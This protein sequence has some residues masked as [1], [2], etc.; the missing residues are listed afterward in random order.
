M[1]NE[2]VLNILQELI[3]D[4]NDLADEKNRMIL[5]AGGVYKTIYYSALA[6]GI[7]EA[8]YKVVE[9]KDELRKLSVNS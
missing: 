8:C 1:T 9:K 4:L 3:D 2:E 5:N 6:A 7:Y